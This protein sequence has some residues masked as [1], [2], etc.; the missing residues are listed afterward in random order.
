MLKK[1]FYSSC[2]LIY[3]IIIIITMTTPITA[4]TTATTAVATPATTQVHNLRTIIKYLD[5]ATTRGIFKLDEIAPIIDAVRFFQTPPDKRNDNNTN[6]SFTTDNNVNKEAYYIN[7]LC[8]M[9]NIAARKGGFTLKE[10]AEL[11]EHV[12]AF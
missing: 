2:F 7:M 3:I 6:T 4:T 1:S 8:N 11:W 12:T 9:C 10:A 5:I